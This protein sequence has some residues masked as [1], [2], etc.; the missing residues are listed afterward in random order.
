[1]LLERDNKIIFFVWYI[2]C[3]E[4][5]ILENLLARSKVRVHTETS[6]IK[7]EQVPKRLSP[8]VWAL[9]HENFNFD[10]DIW[11]SNVPQ[12]KS[13][14]SLQNSDW[15]SKVDATSNTIVRKSR[16]RTF[17]KQDLRLVLYRRRILPR[18]WKFLSARYW[19]PRKLN[20]SFISSGCT[21]EATVHGIPL[22]SIFML[23]VR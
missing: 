14:G 13:R 20:F 21:V 15:M 8:Q 19:L 1:M 9:P 3:T 16:R 5:K 23:A 18:S 4:R 11:S 17:S 22:R 12:Q 6:L 10:S 7:R 2:S